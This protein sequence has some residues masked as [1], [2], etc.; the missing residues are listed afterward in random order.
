MVY[1]TTRMVNFT[2]FNLTKRYRYKLGD[3]TPYLQKLGSFN[4]RLNN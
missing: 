2:M 4:K 1:Y 3:N